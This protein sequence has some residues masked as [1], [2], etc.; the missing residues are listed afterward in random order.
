MK[1]LLIII[2]FAPLFCF[3]QNTVIIQSSNGGTTHT[4]NNDHAYYIQGIPSTENI[5]GVDVSTKGNGDPYG[6]P[7]LYYVTFK[8]YRDFPVTVLF[9]FTYGHP[10][11]SEGPYLYEGSITLDAKESKTLGRRY[12]SPR[13]FKMIVRALN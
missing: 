12:N 7:Y 3:A 10:R 13:N 9:E 4:Q 5:G 1:K 2:A 11:S 8:N 6:N